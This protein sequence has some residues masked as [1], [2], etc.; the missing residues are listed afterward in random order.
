ML[1]KIA[2]ACTKPACN[3][4]GNDLKVTMP[5]YRALRAGRR[6]VNNT[7]RLPTRACLKVL[8][9]SG[10]VH[11]G[12]PWLEHTEL[13]PRSDT[14][15]TR[16]WDAPLLQ[17]TR[18]RADPRAGFVVAT[19]ANVD[20]L[21]A[22]IMRSTKDNGK[23]TKLVAHRHGTE[24][25]QCDH[26][27]KPRGLILFFHRTLLHPVPR[28]P[29]ANAQVQSTRESITRCEAMAPRVQGLLGEAP[30]PGPACERSIAWKAGG[31]EGNNTWSRKERLRVRDA[32]RCH[33]CFHPPS[34]IAAS[35]SRGGLVP[36]ASSSQAGG[37]APAL[38]H[39]Q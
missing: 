30:A 10:T 12:G 18:C 36:R 39:E 27:Q 15:V 11:G 28:G 35:S 4:A 37:L 24:N 23:T 6:S 13:A 38:G 2:S 16:V 22:R 29:C 25:R 20:C 19:L 33:P 26:A 17:L 1:E 32:R 9:N 3:L 31:I 21:R 14:H 34:S 7:V 5:Q 8:L